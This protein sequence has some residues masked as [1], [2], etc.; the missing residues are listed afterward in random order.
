M[1]R[2][3]GLGAN[4]RAALESSLAR[5]R[6][7]LENFEATGKDQQA[8]QCRAKVQKLESRINA[9]TLMITPAGK[10]VAKKLPSQVQ[11][12]FGEDVS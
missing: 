7:A 12:G 11:S 9:K 6:T 10:S 8:A 4:E 1:I 2:N 3:P 5:T